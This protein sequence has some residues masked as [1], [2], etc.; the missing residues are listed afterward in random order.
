MNTFLYGILDIITEAHTY[1]LSLND[2]YEANLTDKQLHFIVIGI[3]GMAMIFI[4]HPLFT[5][6]AKTNHVLAISWIYVFTL[7]ILITFAIEIGQKI[8]H[9]G[10]MDFEDI[11]FGVWGFLLMF[12]IF[13]LI[14]GIIIGIIHLIRDIIRK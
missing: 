14:R 6:L 2:A 7:I 10:V 9:S 11:V 3:I 13:A 5:L 4:V 8:T 12:L 1:I